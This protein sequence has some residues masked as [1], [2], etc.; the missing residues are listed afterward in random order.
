MDLPKANAL[1]GVRRDGVFGV[2]GTSCCCF[3]SP[4]TGEERPTLLAAPAEE[5]VLLPLLDR[6]AGTGILLF[7]C[8]CSVLLNNIECLFPAMLLPNIGL[9]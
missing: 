3:S 4:G 7:V 5:N 1:F 6:D 8:V 9:S 2:D